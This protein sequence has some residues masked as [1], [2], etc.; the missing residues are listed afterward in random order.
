MKVSQ[1]ERE[2]KRNLEAVPAA[3]RTNP[4]EKK[5]EGPMED[6]ELFLSF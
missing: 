3:L 2:E 4:L 1:K 6:G 5:L